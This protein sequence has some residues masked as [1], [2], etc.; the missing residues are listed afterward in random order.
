M[1]IVI[2]RF[3]ASSWFFLQAACSVS[4]HLDPKQ[5]WKKVVFGAMALD[6][7]ILRMAM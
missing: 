3:Y 2:D 6:P 5:G 7:H 1:H 4:V